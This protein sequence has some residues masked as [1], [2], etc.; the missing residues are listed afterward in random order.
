MRVI[1]GSCRSLPLKTPKSLDTRPTT[2]RIKETLFNILMPDVP[3]AIFID[4][5]AGSGGIGIEALSRGAKKAYF[6]EQNVEAASCIT[7]NIKFTKMTDVATLL[8]ADVFTGLYSIHEKSADLIFADPP[9]QEGYEER[10]LQTLSQ[11]PYVTEDTKIIV[12]A[13]IHKDFSFA[14]DYGFEVTRE[15]CYKTN[16][17]VFLMKK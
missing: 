2:D 9:Y 10:L 15:K 5:F 8:K 6:I 7:E 12:E 17:H 16:K 13:D 14:E 4:L 11:M 1:A 3:G